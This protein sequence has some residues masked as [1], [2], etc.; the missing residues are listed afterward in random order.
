M[1]PRAE[2]MAGVVLAVVGGIVFAVLLFH[3]S[4]Q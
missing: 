3:W 1:T 4:M 2:Q